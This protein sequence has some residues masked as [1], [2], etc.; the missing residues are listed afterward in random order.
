MRKTAED[1]KTQEDIM[2]KKETGG[3]YEKIKALPIKP[4]SFVD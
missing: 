4:P 3:N 2:K 1:K